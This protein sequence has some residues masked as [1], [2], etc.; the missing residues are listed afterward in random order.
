MCMCIEFVIQVLKQKNVHVSFP[1]GMVILCVVAND[2]VA[3]VLVI[4]V[5]D[6]VG[7]N[8]AF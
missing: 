7:G 4:I 6:A 5:V 3:V 8:F 2:D 1:A